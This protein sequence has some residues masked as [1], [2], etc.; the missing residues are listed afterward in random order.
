MPPLSFA[1]L[2][3]PSLA[4]RG[5]P[6]ASARPPRLG[7]HSRSPPLDSRL[8]PP[9]P[10]PALHFCCPSCGLPLSSP[11]P[12]HEL[13][14]A[15]G[16]S[17]NV[18]KEG[19]VHLLPPSRADPLRVQHDQRLAKASRSFWESGGFASPRDAVAAEVARALAAG[20]AD[21]PPRLLNAGCGE[22]AY[23]RRL[24]EEARGAW[25][26]C[27]TDENKLAVRYAAKRLRGARFA[28][29]APHRLPL[30]AGSVDA[31]LSAF[32]PAVGPV[33]EE[34]LRVLRPGGALIVAR[35]GSTHLEELRRLAGAAPWRPP[36]ELTQG[37]GENYCRVRTKERV[38]GVALESLLQMTA[39][40]RDAPPERQAALQR[41]V[42]SG[43]MELT[44]D[45]IVSTHRIWLGTGGEPC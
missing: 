40:V 16:H 5:A 15:R 13:R 22:G 43:G 45:V 19:H 44:V 24:W 7:A 4:T 8:A 35:G 33:R 34:F 27:G 9:L 38:E 11:S 37:F 20:G 6:A 18:A 2:A 39:F 36:K 30:E 31:V 23:L 41:V 28:V 14:C 25:Q 26:L 3:A 21:G 12:P 17:Y 29:A 32:A 10:R 42:E 1:W